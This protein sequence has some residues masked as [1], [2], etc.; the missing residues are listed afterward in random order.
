MIH[1]TR[2]CAIILQLLL[3]AVLLFSFKQYTY[4]EP[5]ILHLR[6]L[7]GVTQLAVLPERVVVQCVEDGFVSEFSSKDITLAKPLTFSLEQGSYIISVTGKGFQPLEFELSTAERQVL[8]YTLRLDAYAPDQFVNY[9]FLERATN[10]GQTIIIGYV[11]DWDGKPLPNVDITCIETGEWVTTDSKGYYRLALSVD[12]EAFAR[13][14]EELP[15]DVAI[16]HFYRTLVYKKA[17]YNDLVIHNELVQPYGNGIASHRML[18][19]DGVIEVENTR[20]FD[21]SHS[22]KSREDTVGKIQVAVEIGETAIRGEEPSILN[23]QPP[24]GTEKSFNSCVPQSIVVGFTA[25]GTTCCSG[26][27]SDFN[28]DYGVYSM[29][30]YSKHILRGEWLTTWNSLPNMAEGYKAAAVAIRSYALARMLYNPSSTGFYQICSN[31]CCQNFFIGSIPSYMAS[32]VDATSGVIMMDGNEVGLTEY[33]SE[34]NGLDNCHCVTGCSAGNQCTLS[35]GGVGCW[36]SGPCGDGYFQDPGNFLCI[37]DPVGTGHKQFGHGRGMSQYGSA[38]WASG[39]NLNAACESGPQPLHGYG[40]KNWIE[41]LDH[42]YPSFSLLSGLGTCGLDCSDV[43]AL[44]CGIPISGNTANST[45]NILTYGCNISNNYTGPEL[46]FSVIMEPGPFTVNLSNIVYPPNPGQSVGLSVIVLDGNSG[47]IVEEDPNNNNS[48]CIEALVG[49]GTMTIN[50]PAGGL[51]FIIV[52]GLT[53]VPY[54]GSSN[55]YDEDNGSFDLLVDGLCSDCPHLYDEPCSAL[56]IPSGDECVF[57]EVQNFCA[58]TSFNP[59][60][61][62]CLGDLSEQ[63]IWVRTTAGVAGRL[64]VDTNDGSLGDLEMALYTGSDCDN[65]SL[66]GCFPNGSIND[67]NGWM[68]IA[69]L[70]GLTPGEDIWIRLWDFGFPHEGNFGICANDPDAG[71]ATIEV[72]PTVILK[73]AFDAFHFNTDNLMRTTYADNYL[74]S[75]FQPFNVAPW[76]YAG[77]ESFPTNFSIPTDMVDWVLITIKDGANAASIVYRQAGVLHADGTITAT[78]GS[79]ISFTASLISGYYI[80]V[81]HSNHLPIISANSILPDLNNQI[82]H[83][84]TSSMD[85]AYRNSTL[86]DDPM[87]GLNS[88]SGYYHAMHSGNGNNLDCQVDANDINSLFQAYL[89]SNYYGSED[90]NLDGVVDI[91]DLN[92]LLEGY[93]GNCHLNY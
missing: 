22:V 51:Y 74:M 76:F 87:V 85:M 88:L 60:V 15:P 23:F 72:C 59:P 4:T 43:V 19:G 34:N 69:D 93:N 92:L 44:E 53:G 71:L 84:F 24:Q 78:D 25:S 3:V 77:V 63:D 70:N 80:E 52:D 28:S 27:C 62:N 89:L 86:N 40:T 32:A 18:E 55:D 42:Y 37:E 79:L 61:V 56:V 20:Y 39:I 58:T 7:D 21:L 49:G 31:A 82:C 38:R 41:I 2:L 50:N 48:N 30:L 8:N 67:P 75:L 26:S 83:D 57:T 1:I 47:C 65:L 13:F 33:S 16:E 81:A 45:S 17:G 6:F 90:I 12:Y 35:G 46:V 14:H 68:P 64:I 54:Q 29:D 11:V 5:T 73:G 91:N 36:Q 66:Y 9:E 10:K